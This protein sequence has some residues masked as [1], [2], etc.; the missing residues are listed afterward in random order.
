MATTDDATRIWRTV[1][2][3]G[4]LPG[5]VHLAILLLAMFLGMRGPAVW[6]ADRLLAGAFSVL[7]V[8][9]LTIACPLISVI[10]S[11]TLGLQAER[12][13]STLRLCGG[14]AWGLL[15]VGMVT[16]I[17]FPWILVFSAD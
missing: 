14:L 10:A 5:L 13:W 12:A 17:P 6:I 16:S 4:L 9:T 7:L 11:L 15:L 1:A 3:L 2:I 8:P